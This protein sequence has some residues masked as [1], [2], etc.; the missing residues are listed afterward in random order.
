VHLPILVL[1]GPTAV[2]KTA[3]SLEL[4]ERI[5]AEIVSADSRQVYRELTIGTAK[6][7]PEELALVRH[8]FIDELHLGEPFSAGIFA[9]EATAR[10]ESLH[11]RGLT[12]L[13]TGGSTLYLE[14]LL[15]G[16]SE[17][18]DTSAE[19]RAHLTERLEREGPK[20]LYWELERLDP[21]SARTMDPTKTQR[22]V[23]ALE[24]YFDTGVPLSHFH[25]SAAPP[26]FRSLVFVLDRPRAI[27]YR[28][29]NERVDAM[30]DAGLIEENRRILEAGYPPDLNPLRT[31]GYQEPLAHLRGEID[32]EEMIRR[33]KRSTRRYA[34]RQLTWF[35]RHPE[36]VWLDL[37]AE[38]D[39]ATELVLRRWRQFLRGEG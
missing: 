21:E 3:L 20:E 16:L 13:I 34:K 19:T 29:I 33:L 35:R 14:A 27:L 37:G 30:L 12:A 17:I 28:R 9:R 25:G 5:G 31:I 26:P 23:R 18:P 2:G 8:H 4:A 1:T 15:H 24:V 22:V 39:R 32:L 36:Y 11:Q 6:P 38:G 10:I 7:A